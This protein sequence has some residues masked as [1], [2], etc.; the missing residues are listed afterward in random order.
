M[1]F[2]FFSPATLGTCLLAYLCSWS[3]T[4]REPGRERNGGL[5]SGLGSFST[6]FFSFPPSFLV[7]LIE[8]GVSIVQR[9]WSNERG[10]E[11]KRKKEEEKRKTKSR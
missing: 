6:F 5:H 9:I 3:G 1:H 4:E 11:Q 7:A 8:L 10:E 2:V